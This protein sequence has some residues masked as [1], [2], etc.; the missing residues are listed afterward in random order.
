[1][2]K[3]FITLGVVTAAAMPVAAFA[4]TDLSIGLGL[5]GPVYS[6][7][8]PAVVYEQPA[9]VY[10]APPPPVVYEQPAYVYGPPVAYG[11]TVVYDGYYG[12]HYRRAYGYGYRY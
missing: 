11:P 3:L 5:G 8:P 6:P 10:V 1:M 9:P 7:P 4:H 12:P 2:N